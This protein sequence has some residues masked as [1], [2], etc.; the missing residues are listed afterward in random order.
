MLTA[1]TMRMRHVSLLLV[2]VL[3]GACSRAAA[4][5]Q[6]LA[7]G[8]VLGTEAQLSAAIEAGDDEDGGGSITDSSKQ[9]QKDHVDEKANTE[10]CDAQ[11]GSGAGKCATTGTQGNGASRSETQNLS[12]HDSNQ[13]LEKHKQHDALGGGGMPRN[14]E[15][16]PGQDKSSARVTGATIPT[17]GETPNKAECHRSG[18]NPDVSA[19]RHTTG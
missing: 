3:C 5:D 17:G 12:A 19:N 13:R 2:L 9:S 15:G 6:K 11:T 10:N 8:L 7:A 1:T 4:E 18:G 16:P 14:E